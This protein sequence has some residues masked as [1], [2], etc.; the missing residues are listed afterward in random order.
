LYLKLFVTLSFFHTKIGPQIYCSFPENALDAQLMRRIA[1]LMDH[2]LEEGFFIYNFEDLNSM[3]YYFDIYSDWARG[4]RQML[5]LSVIVNQSVNKEREKNVLLWFIEFTE[6]LQSNKEAYKA[7]HIYEKQKYDEKVQKNIEEN[8]E[9]VKSWLKEIHWKS[10]EEFRDKSEE[11]KIASIFKEKEIFDT[12]EKLSKGAIRCDDLQKWFNENF[13]QSL[14]DGVIKKFIDNQF[15]LITEI[16]YEQHLLLLKEVK[17]IRMPPKSLIEHFDE[18]PKI[19]DLVIQKVK[20]VFDKY[21]PTKEDSFQLFQFI[22]DPKI[23]NVLS[24]LRAGPILKNTLPNLISE[25]AFTSLLE[26]LK[27]LKKH[28]II[29]EFKYKK[30]IFVVLIA[31]IQITTSFPKYL[32]K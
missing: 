2:P 20:K 4:G 1:N 32:R 15:I 26:I 8:E 6:K 24:K 13:K 21:I 27:I 9:L 23:Y 3:N 14:F 16:I 22:A 5:M 17:A 31:D 30:E 25:D 10:L 18:S 28:E 11:E 29:D 19:S 7:F 12:H